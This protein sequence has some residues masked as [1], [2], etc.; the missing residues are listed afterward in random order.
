MINYLTLSSL[1]FVSGL[2]S[3]FLNKKHV[4]VVIISIELVLLS[5]N[6]NFLVFSSFLDDG[7][8]QL[9]AM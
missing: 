7:V 6:F 3:L 4:L 5:I 1:M 2:V 8:G 9:Y